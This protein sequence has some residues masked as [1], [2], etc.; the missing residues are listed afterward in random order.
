MGLEKTW[1]VR[2]ALQ[3]HL[4]EGYMLVRERQRQCVYVC[5]LARKMREHFWALEEA[6]RYWSRREHT[7]SLLQYLKAKQ[8][9]TWNLN[10]T[11]SSTVKARVDS[12]VFLPWVFSWWIRT[13]RITKQNLFYM[14]KCFGTALS[15]QK[16]VTPPKKS[17]KAIHHHLS[18]IIR[19]VEGTSLRRR[20]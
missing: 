5:G 3:N 8:I 15:K 6:L 13:Y 4:Q 10:T 17:T 7:H 12:I 14:E 2:K 11:M 18:S 1:V 19:K 20:K 9:V 16:K